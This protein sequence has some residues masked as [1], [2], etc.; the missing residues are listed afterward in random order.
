M[1]EGNVKIEVD[2]P[3][4]YIQQFYEGY[5]YDEDDPHSVKKH[6]ITINLTVHT[7]RKRRA[8]LL[9]EKI[10]SGLLS[11]SICFFGDTIDAPEWNQTGVRHDE[12]DE[13]ISLLI[14]LYRELNLNF[15]SP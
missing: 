15:E 12:L 5:L 4:D 14:S 11:Y 3:S 2:S 6:Q 1:K 10:S 8:L 13:F 7:T 9:V